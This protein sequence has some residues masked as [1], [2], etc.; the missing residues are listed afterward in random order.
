MRWVPILLLLLCLSIHAADRQWQSGKWA[1][2]GVSRNLLVGDPRSGSPG[3][4]PAPFHSTNPEIG[5]YIIETTDA[6]YTIE[7]IVPLGGPGS[8]D[9]AVKLGGS[10]TFAVHRST[11]YIKGD[12]VEWRLRL[13]KKEPK[14]HVSQT[15][16][17]L[18]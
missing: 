11:V 5:R 17:E 14:P 2:A 9:L 10:V 18:R 12:G 15:R 8:F 16:P 6:R 1:D 7:D 4:L 3:A 13:V